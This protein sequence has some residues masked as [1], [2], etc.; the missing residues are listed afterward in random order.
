MG[1]AHA[2]RRDRLRGA[3]VD[4]GIDALLV[5]ALVNVRYLTGFTGT[6][7]SVLVTADPD[8]DRFATDGRYA[9]QASRE[10]GDVAHVITRTPDWLAD[11]VPP[12]ARLGVEG[13]AMPWSDALALR[14]LLPDRTVG[15]T[16]A[17]VEALRA[18]KDDEEIAAIRAA[19]RIGDEA[20]S[21]TLEIIRPGT[22]ER[23][24]A[25]ALERTMVDLGAAERAFP[26]IVAS[27][28]NGAVPH[29]RPTE[30][31][32]EIGDLVTLDF[33]AVVDGYRSDMTRMVAIGHPGDALMET[34]ALVRAAQ[35]AG[36]AAVRDGVGGAAVDAACRDVI[37]DA[38]L[39]E[40]FSTAPVM[41]SGWTCT[42]RRVWL[43]MQRI[44]SAVAWW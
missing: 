44:H 37:A 30:R 4:A 13:D 8:D 42:R 29:H 10:V 9:D 34:V 28:P 33:G 12:G 23:E 43:L 24:V 26:S 15:P 3:L 16:R 7:G 41:A 22:T 25:I 5:T 6:A 1:H 40:R 20:L 27:G 2:G 36:V 17:A 32:L 31:V 18:C 38:G 21:S 11:A 39:G 14:S 19:C 35:Q